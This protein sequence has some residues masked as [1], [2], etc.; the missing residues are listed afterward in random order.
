MAPGDR[1]GRARVPAPRRSDEDPLRV[2]HVAQPVGGGVAEYVAEVAI[3]QARRGWRVTVAGPPHGT[4]R[5]RLDDAGVGVHLHPWSAGRGRARRSDVNAL[6]EL[7]ASAAP[8]VVHLHSST[9]GLAGRLAVRGR[10]PTIFQ[11]HAWAW[12]AVGPRLAPVLQA[13][14]RF[15]LR[16]TSAV[17]C[18]GGEEAAAGRRAGLGRRIQVI[19]SGVD[20]E[21]F[22]AADAEERVVTRAHLGLPAS[23]PVVL[24]VG[25][26]TR[27]KGQDVLVAAWPRVRAECP[28]AV[29]VLVGDIQGDGVRIRA[30]AEG[31]IRQWGAV[32]DVGPWYVAAD[33]VAAPSRWEGLALTAIEAMACGRPVVA[34]DVP[35]LREVFRAGSLRFGVGALVPPEDPAALADA[36]VARLRDGAV[37]RGEEDAA[38]RRATDFDV[39]VT[40]DELA[41]LTV[42]LA[43]RFTT[44]SIRTARSASG[45]PARTRG[46][47][48]TPTPRS[49]SSR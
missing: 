18:V 13:G 33:V 7:V 49:G 24:C 44:G 16:W 12:Q 38:R 42:E 48:R 9:A 35:G 43:G 6:R 29:L 47:G 37:R 23:A 27:Q 32:E 21:R 40:N 45:T 39:R 10:I 2:L 36:L 46:S 11:P 1:V 20:L 28:D 8:D 15:A 4:V 25:R 19:R 34:S 22:R 30:G 14:E 17:V 31:G 26:C 3:D 5:R 41:S